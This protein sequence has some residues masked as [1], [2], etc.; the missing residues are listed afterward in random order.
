MALTFRLQ[1]EV[2]MVQPSPTN[3]QNLQMTS[4]RDKKYHESRPY[5]PLIIK[6]LKREG[7]QRT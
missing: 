1:L 5:F 3:I 4:A 6:Y 7:K 2:T